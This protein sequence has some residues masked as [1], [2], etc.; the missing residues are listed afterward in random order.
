MQIL[1][2][3]FAVDADRRPQFPSLLEKW[4]AIGFNIPHVSMQWG[5]QLEFYEMKTDGK[6]LGAI[7]NAGG[8]WRGPRVA[9]IRQLLPFERT[10]PFVFQDLKMGKEYI[11][12]PVWSFC[13]VK[14]EVIGNERNF[15][16]KICE[17]EVCE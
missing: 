14:E 17:R 4:Y 1:V 7:V 11:R 8:P 3:N 13:T 5:V 2:V 10:P 16:V 9:H 12:V 6:I 15:C